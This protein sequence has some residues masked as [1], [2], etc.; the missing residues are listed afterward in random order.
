[1]S[2]DRSINAVSERGPRLLNVI[3]GVFVAALV[4]ATV[5][6][7]KIVML[8]PL[9]LPGGTIV[10]P[11][12]FIINDILTEVYG[13]ARSRRVVWTALACQAL[14]GLLFLI[15]DYMPPAPFWKGQEAF[16]AILGFVPRV[17]LAGLLAFFSG[18]LT[19]S[20][21]ISKMKYFEKG[22]RGLK[23]GWRFVASTIAG[24]AVDSLVFMTVAFTGQIPPTDLLQ[25]IMT[26]YFVKV[27]YEVIALPVSVPFSNWLKKK[28]S[29]DHIDY[30]NRTNYNPFLL[31]DRD[32]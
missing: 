19:N 7:S 8:G 9:A 29:I 27:A 3:T 13:Y 22:E 31:R 14:A 20:F 30:P 15:V 25:T 10:F 28:E 23:Q 2:P 1:M 6:S 24:E 18:E 16:H 12:T 26:L 11:V 5:I 21:V 17:A 32:V 4:I